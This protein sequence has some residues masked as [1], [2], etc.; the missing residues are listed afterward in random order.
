MSYQFF[1]L[2]PRL[3]EIDGCY[4]LLL[5]RKDEAPPSDIDRREVEDAFFELFDHIEWKAPDVAWMYAAA[6]PF[7]NNV[8]AVAD[9]LHASGVNIEQIVNHFARGAPRSGWEQKANTWPRPELLLPRGQSFYTEGGPPAS[10]KKSKS[11]SSSRSAPPQRAP[12]PPT[13]LRL[14]ES[15]PEDEVE[16]LEL[17]SETDITQLTRLINSLVQTMQIELT[18]DAEL[19]DLA[20]DMAPLFD[21]RQPSGAELLEF[22]MEHRYI[23]EVFTDAWQLDALLSVW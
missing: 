16:L 15:P 20:Y 22:L 8:K 10:R 21:D 1:G 18:K 17:P 5:A 9:T 6:R 7:P 13:R 2:T 19:A 4:A 11:S 23:E 3:Q 14:V 12:T